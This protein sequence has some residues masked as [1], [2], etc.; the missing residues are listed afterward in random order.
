MNRRK[1]LPWHSLHTLPWRNPEPRQASHGAGSFSFIRFVLPDLYDD[2]PHIRPVLLGRRAKIKTEPPR[3]IRGDDSAQ[4]R[5]ARVPQ[6]G[7]R[8]L[9]KHQRAFHIRQVG[10]HAANRSEVPPSSVQIRKRTT[11]PAQLLSMHVHGSLQRPSASTEMREQ[12][13]VFEDDIL[14]SLV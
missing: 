6:Y 4:A 12:R 13:A 11:P 10:D 2:R 5:N 8:G 9:R 1:P 14:E 7:L 3:Y